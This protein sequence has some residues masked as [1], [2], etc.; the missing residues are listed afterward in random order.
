MYLLRKKLKDNKLVIEAVVGVAKKMFDGDAAKMD[1]A[2]EFATGCADI[3]D[4][5]RCEASF[6]I[7]ECIKGA[8]KAK[9]L[10]SDD[11]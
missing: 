10:T 2:R 11:M 4:G 9:G 8:A 7:F 5:D 1:L 6:K 3:T